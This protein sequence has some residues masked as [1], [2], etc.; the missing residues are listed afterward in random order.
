MNNSSPL[1]LTLGPLSNRIGPV[2]PTHVRRVVEAARR[3]T[4]NARGERVE[5]IETTIKPSR[6]GGPGVVERR[7]LIAMQ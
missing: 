3:V 5:F 1:T 6:E 2:G 4:M 7:T